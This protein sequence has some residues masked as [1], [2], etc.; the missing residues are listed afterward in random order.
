MSETGNSLSGGPPPRRRKD[1]E[2]I[3]TETEPASNMLRQQEA[4]LLTEG[5]NL[6]ARRRHGLYTHAHG[7]AHTDI[8][9]RLQTAYLH[10]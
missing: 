5:I 10:N 3:L 6:Q 2:R 4:L 1:F 7:C 9:W 8:H